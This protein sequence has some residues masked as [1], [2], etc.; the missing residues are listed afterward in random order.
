MNDRYPVPFS[1][2]AKNLKPT[3]AQ[4]AVIDALVYHIRT[5]RTGI[6]P[7]QMEN[8]GS[9]LVKY[10]VNPAISSDLIWSIKVYTMGDIAYPN[11]MRLVLEVQ[12]ADGMTYR[13]VMNVWGSATTTTHGQ[14]R[15]EEYHFAPLGGR[16]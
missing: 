6:A 7:A 5:H 2:E 9:L 16:R 4:A 11:K 1:F 12:H 15:V 8:L 3:T 10:V 14:E 13:S